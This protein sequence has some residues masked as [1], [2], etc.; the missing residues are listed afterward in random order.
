MRHPAQPRLTNAPDSDPGL[1]IDT[2]RRR[3]ALLFD[4]GSCEGL[5][6]EELAR[7]SHVFISHTH[8]DHFMGF[9]GLLRNLLGGPKTLFV[10]GP[11][12]I[13][14]HLGHRLSA[15]QWNLVGAYADS[16][17]IQVTEIRREC[18]LRQTFACRR[19]F[20]PKTAPAQTRPSRTIMENDRWRVEADI[21]DHRTPC[22]GFRINGRDR[23]T[24]MT[25][26]LAESGYATGPWLGRLKALV[27][28][29]AALS[30][31]RLDVTTSTG[32]Q[33]S[34]SAAALS[35]RL[36]RRRPGPV[37]AYITDAV[38]SAANI[39]KITRLARHADHLF[40]EAPFLSAEDRHAAAKHHLTAH[41]A[42]TLAAMAGAKHFTI[43]HFSPRYRGRFE[44]LAAEARDAYDRT[45]SADS[46]PTAGG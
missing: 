18:H 28:E 2:E 41:Q 45:I 43:F 4:V 26:A 34:V 13:V 30:T 38:Y 1:F 42:G 39:P 29:D 17:L 36:I 37:F 15:Y 25:A 24:V 14:R 20:K 16:A 40:I 23:L 19:A 21:L 9:D 10:Y 35:H 11:Q 33:T 6:K 46:Q 32:Q 7:V 5:D 31:V 8:M 3:G 12:G 22:L 44:D 27:A